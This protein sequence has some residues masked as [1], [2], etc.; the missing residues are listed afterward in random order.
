MKNLSVL[1]LGEPG[2]GKTLAGLSF[3]GV[4]HHV[5]GSREHDTA[6]N[7]QGRTDILP[8]VTMNWQDEYTAKDREEIAKIEKSADDILV[9]RKMKEIYR[10]K[11]KAR[12]V[13]KYFDYLESLKGEIEA[14]KR[15]ELKTIFLDNFTPYQEDLW[16]YTTMLHGSDYTEKNQWNLHTDFQNDI[17]HTFDL[18]DKLGLNVVV[19]CHV[20]MDLEEETKAKTNF[21]EQAKVANRKEW[22]P[23][24]QGKF[25]YQ[26][27]GK[28]SYA[29]YMFTEEA[30]GQD[31]KYF[32]KIICDSQ[33][34]GV[35]KNRFN[36]FEGNSEHQS[37]RKIK[38]PKGSFYQ[39]LSEAINKQG[40]TK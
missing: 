23:N 15:P 1:L 4:E 11:A 21:L 20:S 5:W 26:L 10:D 39:F 13:A 2:V 6:M 37:G 19:S 16:T 28:F 24:M 14:G 8:P 7:F 17:K 36:P 3:P 30:L 35:A 18:Y 33:N 38:M 27:A 32:S 9:K 12:A 31:T 34:V 22:F 40:G 25:K 29:F